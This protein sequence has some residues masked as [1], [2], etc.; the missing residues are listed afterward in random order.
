MLNEYLTIAEARL[1]FPEGARP[2]Y[3]TLVR[4]A[5]D[6]RPTAGGGRKYMK[7]S[8][9]GNQICV[10]RGDLQLFLSNSSNGIR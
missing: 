4:W 8:R 1:E 3:R 5:H 10:R 9:L 7:T 6:G 2:S